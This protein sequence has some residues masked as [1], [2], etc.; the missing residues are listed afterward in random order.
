MQISIR[1]SL[2]LHPL[3]VLGLQKKSNWKINVEISSAGVL[4]NT[5]PSSSSYIMTPLLT[6]GV[7]PLRWP[8]AHSA[9]CRSGL[10]SSCHL[11]RQQR[12]SCCPSQSSRCSCGSSR[13]PGL[14]GSAASRPASPA[15]TN[16]RPCRCK[17]WWKSE[18]GAIWFMPQKTVTSG[19]SIKKVR[20][21]AICL[22][23][24]TGRKT[25][26]N[27]CS[28]SGEQV[29]FTLA[30]GMPGRHKAPPP[31]QPAPTPPWMKVAFFFYQQPA[32]KY[33]FLS[34]FLSSF[35]TCSVKLCM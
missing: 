11:P 29:F 35:D 14:Q 26:V 13:Q 9:Q 6:P 33:L 28:D 17:R 24:L 1:A 32:E 23:L 16:R 25:R 2:R 20:L 31:S 7:D 19:R 12:C 10:S 21:A 5:P 34:L 15:A 27:Y 3:H 30:D 8:A 18:E 4:W 22:G